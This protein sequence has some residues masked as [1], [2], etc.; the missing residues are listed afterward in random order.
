MKAKRFLSIFVA[1]LMLVSC[2]AIGA[3]ADVEKKPTTGTLNIHLYETANNSDVALSDSDLS[4]TSADLATGNYKGVADV[5]FTIVRVADDAA[6]AAT[7]TALTGE[8]A[9]STTAT[10]NADGLATAANLPAGRYKVYATAKP[11]NVGEPV[12]FL[13][14]VPMTSPDG[15][16]Y[17]DVVDVYPKITVTRD[18]PTVNKLVAAVEN[19]TEPEDKAYTYYANLGHDQQASWRIVSTVPTNIREFNKYELVDIVSDNLVVLPETLTINGNKAGSFE[20]F[21]KSAAFDGQVLTIKVD[22]KTAPVKDIVV[23]FR[24]TIKDNMPGT[25]IPNHVKLTYNDSPLVP[26]PDYDPNTDEDE[27]TNPKV[28]PSDSDEDTNNWDKP[29]EYDTDTPGKDKDPYVWT[30]AVKVVKKDKATGQTI[31]TDT[32]E[33]ALYTNDQGTGEPVATFATVNGVA[34][35]KGLLDGTYYLFETKAP[36]GYELSTACITVEITNGSTA[37]AAIEFENIPS[38]KLPLTGG[39]GVGLFALI[40]LAFAAVGGAFVIKSRKASDF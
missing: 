7:A 5:T 33:F 27:T 29:E 32:A 10:T 11:D 15:K 24:T 14:D 37:S 35:Y 16:G 13:V 31:V 12:A 8:K 9:Y 22:P 30:G 19:D 6:D 18:V 38:T 3:S 25:I 36:A 4:G 23:K 40:G 20:S 34:E 28:K 21:I 17:N 2:F 26:N 1:V 39:M